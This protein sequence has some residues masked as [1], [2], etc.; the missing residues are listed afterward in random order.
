MLI[1][2]FIDL[3]RL[4]KTSIKWKILTES[5]NEKGVLPY[6]EMDYIVKE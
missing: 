4:M 3:A 2:I 5:L 6:L 1:L